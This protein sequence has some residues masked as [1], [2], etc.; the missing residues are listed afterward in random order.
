MFEPETKS[1]DSGGTQ[2]EAVVF[3]GLYYYVTERSIQYSTQYTVC[4]WFNSHMHCNLCASEV[5]MYLYFYFIFSNNRYY[6]MVVVLKEIY[7]WRLPSMYMVCMQNLVCTVLYSST[8]AWCHKNLFY[9]WKYCTV[10]V[11]F[12]QLF[13]KPAE[14]KCINV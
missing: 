8:W 5:M 3:T 4:T 1:R 7:H 6:C 14:K 9:F 2:H 13:R 10:F 11:D 12:Y